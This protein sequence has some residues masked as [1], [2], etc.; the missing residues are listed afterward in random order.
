MAAQ[1]PS[2]APM[3]APVDW[4]TGRCWFRNLDARYPFGFAPGTAGGCSDTAALKKVHALDFSLQL[5][6]AL[7]NWSLEKARGG[8]A[9]RTAIGTL[10]RDAETTLTVDGLTSVPLRR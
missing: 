3:V 9:L 5:A 1:W 7:R 10:T 2:V 8:K 4:T 6:I